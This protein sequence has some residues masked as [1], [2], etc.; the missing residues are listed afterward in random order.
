MEPTFIN[1]HQDLKAHIKELKIRKFNEEAALNAS[2]EEFTNSLN[3]S[4]LIKNTVGE[5]IPPGD[6]AG[7][8]SKA[9]LIAGA[10]LVID[11]IWGRHKTV[12]GFLSSLVV[13]NISSYIINRNLFGVITRIKNKFT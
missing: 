5:L 2:F 6:V 11:Q 4:R 12:I 13:R 7:S 3:P 10:N 9:G 8:L 1:N